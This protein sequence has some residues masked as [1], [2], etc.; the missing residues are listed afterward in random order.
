MNVQH[1][2]VQDANEGIVQAKIGSEGNN[3]ACR[4]ALAK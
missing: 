4:H 1:H 2:A 3:A